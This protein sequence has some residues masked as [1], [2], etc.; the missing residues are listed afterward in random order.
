M[1]QVGDKVFAMDYE[2]DDILVI[3]FL[4][5]TRTFPVVGDVVSFIDDKYLNVALVAHPENRVVR[6]HKH[7]CY[8]MDDPIPDDD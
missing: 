2:H 8:T 3:K 4:G 5:D 7:D 1:I 6:V